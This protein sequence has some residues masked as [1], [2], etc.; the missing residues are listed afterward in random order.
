MGI[1][2]IDEVEEGVFISE[3]DRRSSYFCPI[4]THC[5]IHRSDIILGT[6]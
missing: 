6:H 4:P 1:W 3:L 2:M 5:I